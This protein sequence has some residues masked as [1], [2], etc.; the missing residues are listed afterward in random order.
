VDP[1]VRLTDPKQVEAQ[2]IL[3][4]DSLTWDDKSVLLDLLYDNDNEE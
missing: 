1:T 2:Q 4:D 3:D